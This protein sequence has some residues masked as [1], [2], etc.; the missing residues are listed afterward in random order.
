MESLTEAIKTAVTTGE[1]MVLRA[2]ALYMTDHPRL[3]GSPGFLHD[4]G[5]SEVEAGH[6]FNLDEIVHCISADSKRLRVSIN[7]IRIFGPIST[8]NFPHYH[9]YSREELRT[10]KGAFHFIVLMVQMIAPYDISEN[11]I[12]TSRRI[13]SITVEGEPGLILLYESEGFLRTERLS[14]GDAIVLPSGVYHTFAA[15]PGVFAS[16][17]AIEICDNPDVMYQAHYEEKNRDP[18]E[19]VAN[20]IESLTGKRPPDSSKLTLGDIPGLALYVEDR[21]GL[22]RSAPHRAS[23]NVATVC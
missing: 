21:E 18:R 7:N 22:K 12:D 10:K 17:G 13:E 3:V 23:I 1:C 2:S 8:R 16:Y 11:T 6:S 19:V 14:V 4:R 20:T 15:A 5:N 9:G